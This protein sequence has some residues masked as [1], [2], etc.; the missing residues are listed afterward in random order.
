[1]AAKPTPFSSSPPY[2]ASPDEWAHFDV[3]LGLT[4][5]LLPVVSN[6]NAKISEHSKMRDLGKTPSRYNQAGFVAGIAKWSQ[7]YATGQEIDAWSRRPDYGICIQ[8]RTVRAL[9]VDVT[10]PEQAH[11]IAQVIARHLGQLPRR[12]RNN[13]SKALFAFALPGEFYK[14]TIRTEHGIIEFLAQGQQFIAVGTHPSGA[15]YEWQGGLPESFPEV[16]KDAFERLWLELVARFATEDPTE[17][18][19]STKLKTLDAAIQ[20]DATAQALMDKDMVLS[21]ERDGRLHIICPFADE[22]TT[23]SSESATTYFPANTGGYATGHFKCLHAHCEHRSDEDFRQALGVY[24]DDFE[25]IPEE[26]DAPS[27]EQLE[28]FK[29]VPAAEFAVAAPAKWIIKDVL[30]QAT[31]AVV[32]GG[33]GSGKT[34]FMLDMVGAIA[35]GQPWRGKRTR[36]GRVVYIV[37]EGAGGFRS[38]LKAWAQQNEVDLASV[39]IGVVGDAPNLM[40]APDV[41]ALLAAIKDFGPTDVIVVDTLAQTMPG[42]DENSAESV[43]KALLHCRMLHLQT[44]ALVVL[45]HHAGK[46]ASKGARGWSGLR[47]AADAEI[48]ISRVDNDRV[49]SV[50]KMKDGMDGAEFGFR[51]NTIVVGVDDDGDDITSCVIEHTDALPRAQRRQAGPKG[52][53][54]R[55]VLRTLADLQGLTGDGVTASELID[56]AVNQLT[57]PEEGKRDRRREVVLR[58]LESLIADGVV[59]KNNEQLAILGEEQ[60]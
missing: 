17:S 31:L 39:E 48:E 29:V 60:P 34:F 44:G 11:A 32:Y 35:Q 3:I 50:T 58:A 54:E 53:N 14:R 21:S 51:L 45:V 26:D 57:G 6:P 55:I 19:A 18:K 52:T 46:D 37:A 49:A 8:T 36:K 43:G 38:R 13:S 1:M 40:A 25:V 28:R 24:E 9:D 4:T 30:P 33:A 27:P 47:A 16:P 41:K 2:G 23:D 42:G 22:H 7:H 59:V 5:D 20:S 12:W 56:A 10:D 15:R